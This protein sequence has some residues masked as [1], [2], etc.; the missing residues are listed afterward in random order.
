MA[1]TSNTWNQALPPA[2]WMCVA[3]SCPCLKESLSKVKTRPLEEGDRLHQLG[4]SYL[5][6]S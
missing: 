3:S 1:E 2:C 4:N 5:G 6:L